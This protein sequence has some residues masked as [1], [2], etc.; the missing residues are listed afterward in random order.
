MCDNAG[1]FAGGGGDNDFEGWNNAV[2]SFKLNQLG[3][4]W[5]ANAWNIQKE[6]NPL[7]ESF[8]V[9]CLQWEGEAE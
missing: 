5:G 2:S 9:P 4:P 8:M 3:L 1:S 7:K 6:L